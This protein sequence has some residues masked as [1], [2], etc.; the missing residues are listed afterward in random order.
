MAFLVEMVVDRGMDGGK[1]LQTSHA[2]EPEHRP[3]PSSKRQVRILRPV[4]LPTAGFLA[5]SRTDHLQRCPIGP[6]FV[7]DKDMWT[8]VTFH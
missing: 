5:V 7:R 1:F 6:E 2:P 3:F 4:V 8:T